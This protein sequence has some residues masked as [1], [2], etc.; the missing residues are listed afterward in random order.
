M[1][2]TYCCQNESGT[3]RWKD[4]D[5]FCSSKIG[6][7]GIPSKEDCTYD[8]DIPAVCKYTGK[9]DDIQIYNAGLCNSVPTNGP[10][11]CFCCVDNKEK[12]WDC[13]S[14]CEGR[15]ELQGVS[16]DRTICIDK[17]H[18]VECANLVED[19]DDVNIEVRG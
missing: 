5:P 8:L 16:V 4:C 15:P 19:H 18:R 17:V 6:R 12:W 10:L 3:E 14:T 1:C 2:S 9:G 11:T 7:V 13:S